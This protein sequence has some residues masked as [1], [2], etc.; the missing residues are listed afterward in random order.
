LQA[1][2]TCTPPVSVVLQQLVLPN[3]MQARL[4]DTVGPIGP[5]DS[6]HKKHFRLSHTDNLPLTG[7][8]WWRC[9]QTRSSWPPTLPPA[10]TAAHSHPACDDDVRVHSGAVGCSSGRSGKLVIR[11]VHG[12][13]G[14][15]RITTYSH[16]ANCNAPTVMQ[17]HKCGKRQSR[18]RKQCM[19][20]CVCVGGG[21][22]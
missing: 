14:R 6:V 16:G 22:R 7:K 5:E 19:Y 20:V 8:L 12:A 18:W 10:L 13:L 4:P 3:P 15:S 17:R 9:L 21:V 11:A 2:Y 1:P